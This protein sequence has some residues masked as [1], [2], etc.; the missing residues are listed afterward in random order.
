MKT[1]KSGRKWIWGLL[2]IGSITLI[3]T[4][5]TQ[6]SREAKKEGAIAR[7]QRGDVSVSVQEVGSVEPFRKVEIKSKVPGQVKQVLVDVGDTVRENAVLIQLDPLDANREVS[8]VQARSKVTEA[9]L[10]RARAEHNI[11]LRAHQNGALSDLE[12]AASEGQVKRLE[13]QGR[14]EEVEL[15]LSE[16]RRSYTELRSPIAGVVLVRNVQPGEMVTPGVS[17][18][19]DG[20]PLLVVAQIEKLLVRTELNQ[21][22]VSRIKAK[23]RVEVR[24]D[25][26]RGLVFDGEVY[27]I[28]AMAQ[29]SERRKDSNLLVFPVDVVVRR[30]QEGATGL[31]PGMLADITIALETRTNVLTVPLEALVREGNQTKLR[32]VVE[33]PEPAETLVEVTIGLQND[34][35]VEIVS[36]VSE[37]EQIRVQ[38]GAV[39]PE[40]LSK[41]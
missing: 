23:D 10:F 24:V 17:S 5:F 8:Q 20:K 18:M 22:D 6:G 2:L 32:R 28:A 38:P 25:A 36:G 12:L 27:R 30:D 39:P 7:V 3:V 31:R 11:K 14:L 9:E 1:K 19:V 21:I 40:A 35:V 13:A 26:L 34:R 16:D 33:G 29:R 37:G 41:V 15:Q 4:G